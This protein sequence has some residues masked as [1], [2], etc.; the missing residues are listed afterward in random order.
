VLGLGLSCSTPS[1][2]TVRSE[3]N[4]RYPKATVKQS[5]LIF[6][7]DGVAV[8]RVIAEVQGISGEAEYDFALKRHNGMWSWCD[9]QTERKCR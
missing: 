3:F 5:E 9:D 4:D 6:E 8:Y 1:D 2:G 7:Q